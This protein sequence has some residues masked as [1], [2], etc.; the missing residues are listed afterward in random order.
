[1]SVFPDARFRFCDAAGAEIRRDDS[2]QRAEHPTSDVVSDVGRTFE[3]W[4]TVDFIFVPESTIPALTPP[5]LDLT[6]DVMALQTM[7]RSRASRHIARASEWGSRYIY[8]MSSRD[9]VDLSRPAIERFFWPHP[10]PARRDPK[11][12]EMRVA[13]G[14]PGDPQFAHLVGWRRI[15]GPA[16]KESSV[17]ASLSGDAVAG[18]RP[19]PE[20][21][22]R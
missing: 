7:T 15:I 13:T 11:L 6:V 18:E 9:Q 3:D 20:L 14:L 4:Q 2:G 19:L 21:L 5:R 1:M 12:D 10:V 8:T 22:V 16:R 17:S